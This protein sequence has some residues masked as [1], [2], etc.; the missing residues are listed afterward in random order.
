MYVWVFIYI[1]SLIA[2]AKLVIHCAIIITL[3]GC[4]LVSTMYMLQHIK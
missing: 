2:N 1:M 3:E 4:V